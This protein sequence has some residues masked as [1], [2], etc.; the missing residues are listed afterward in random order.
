MIW[1]NYHGHCNYCDGYQNIEDYI[2]EAI[3]KKMPVIGISSHAPV[4]FDCFWTMKKERLQAYNAE[5]QELQKKYNSQITLLRSLEVDYVPHIMGCDIDYV[6]ELELD[7][8]VGSIHFMDRLKDG[9][10]WAIDGS[11]EEFEQG[12]V[13]IFNGDIKAVVKEFYRLNREMVNTQNFEIIG[14]IDKIKMHNVVKPLFDEQSEWYKK[15]VEETLDLIAEKNII[16]EINT[17]SYKKN[18]LL[19]PGE[20]WFLTMKA[21]GISVTIN[22]DAHYPDKLTDGF[23]EVA[24]MLKNAGYT[25]L[26]E[27]YDGRWQEVPFSENG[28]SW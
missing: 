13:E 12:L 16:V 19:F 8:K 23:N 25:T 15:E 6:N 28:L 27:Y 14:H 22:S 24:A 5:L 9:T 17:K 20:E 3:K 1:T 21:K 26:K 10:Y 2:Q 7:Y 18:G 4:P 11:F